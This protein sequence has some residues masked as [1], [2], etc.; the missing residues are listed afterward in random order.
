MSRHHDPNV[1]RAA[2]RALAPLVASG[3]AVCPR[4]Q[5]PIAPGQA[6][7]A[8]HVDDLAL[9]GATAGPMVPEHRSCGSSAGATLGNQLRARPRRRLA[10]W[11]RVARREWAI[12]S[13][14]IGAHVACPCQTE[15]EP[16][17]FWRTDR[18]TTPR[19][20]L[21]LPRFPHFRPGNGVIEHG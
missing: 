7:Q 3:L 2:R 16:V 5:R 12:A 8:G 21:S 10:A 20:L 11:L 1:Q 6:W 18:R 13:C 14:A 17:F 15:R 9:G 19:V 4:C